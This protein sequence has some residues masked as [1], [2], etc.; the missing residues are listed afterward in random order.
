MDRA[1]KIRFDLRC[2]VSSYPGALCFL[3]SQGVLRSSRPPAMQESSLVCATTTAAANAGLPWIRLLAPFY[4]PTLSCEWL[5]ASVDQKE[6]V[7]VLSRPPKRGSLYP[8]RTR[9]RNPTK[10][11]TTTFVYFIVPVSLRIARLCCEF[12]CFCSQFLF[13]D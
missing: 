10:R 3:L 11:E 6:T 4:S 1:C 9:R 7:Q 13:Y 8:E 2:G 5:V 12:C